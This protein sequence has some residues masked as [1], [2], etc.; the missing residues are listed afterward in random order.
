MAKKTYYINYTDG[1][2]KPSFN[3]PFGEVDNSTSLVLYGQG[4]KEYAE[5]LWNNLLHLLENFSNGNPNYTGP[6]NPTE[7]QLWYDSF[8]RVLKVYKKVNKSP[9]ALEIATPA[10]TN[11]SKQDEYIWVDIVDIEYMENVFGMDGIEGV[12]GKIASLAKNNTDLINALKTYYL[13]YSGGQLTGQLYLSNDTYV[14][15]NNA[16]GIYEAFSV[17]YLKSYLDNFAKTYKPEEGYFDIFGNSARIDDTVGTYV[18]L[19]L[20]SSKTISGSKVTF[21]NTINFSNSLEV[22]SAVNDTDLVKRLDFDNSITTDAIVDKIKTNVDFKKLVSDA[23]SLELAKPE[24][25]KV[26]LTPTPAVLSSYCVVNSI[27]LSGNDTNPHIVLSQKVTPQ[28]INSRFLITISLILSNG[29]KAGQAIG[30]LYKNDTALVEKFAVVEN[31]DTDV[32]PSFY[33]FVDSATNT[34]E[35]T[36]TVKVNGTKSGTDIWLFNQSANKKNFAT[37]TMTILEFNQVEQPSISWTELINFNESIINNGE[38]SGRIKISCE[39]CTINN[40]F[41]FA[42]NSA[43]IFTIQASGNVTFTNVNAILQNNTDTE[44][45]FDVSG[46]INPN[47]I[48]TIVSLTVN[49]NIFNIPTGFTTI[50]NEIK[51]LYINCLPTAPTTTTTIAASTTTTAGPTTST[52]LAPNVSTTTLA[53][54]TSTTTAAPTTTT[55]EYVPKIGEEYKGGFYLGDITDN[56]VK[57]RIIVSPKSVEGRAKWRS[58]SAPNTTMGVTSLTDGPGNTTKLTATPGVH[59]AADYCANLSVNNY[60]DWYLPAYDELKQMYTNHAAKPFATNN[61]FASSD[62]SIHWSSSENS[63]G[64][65]WEVHLLSNNAHTTNP[66]HSEYNVRAVR[67]EPY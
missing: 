16:P 63:S 29:S 66:E 25:T 53:P 27:P 23:V 56:N 4:R 13:Q 51:F 30:G 33:T 22:S 50:L 42:A 10:N 38:F 39:N 64:A 11:A 18:P 57:Y 62:S 19:D 52:T 9:L 24:N 21:E 41:N 17:G 5:G 15:Y 44:I 67:R 12:I 31:T 58:S 48:D 65:A 45:T 54:T 3:I 26:I 6:D 2:N 59:L 14:E 28:S 1:L 7:G 49:R 8:N 55:T 61:G 32:F 47:E 35:I 43:N 37:S 46:I 34:N 20:T 36:Y 40:S 60:S